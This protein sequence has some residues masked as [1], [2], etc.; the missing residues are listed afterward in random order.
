MNREIA[1]SES[2]PMIL[3]EWLLGFMACVILFGPLVAVSVFYVHP[4]HL[5]LSATVETVGIGVILRAMLRRL[6]RSGARGAMQA[7]MG[8][9]TR[10]SSRTMTRR[11]AR[12]GVKSL[13]SLF[14]RTAS[15]S[16]REAL[17]ES[18]M[19]SPPKSAL[20]AVGLGFVALL[21]SLG[22][23]F[24]VL[25]LEQPLGE[26]PQLAAVLGGMPFALAV[27][28]GAVPILVYAGLL[29]A[30]AP[31]CGVEIKFRT[32]LEALLLQAY[33]TGSGSF[34]PLST[35]SVV[36]GSPAA[37]ARLALVSL[38]GLLAMHLGF[39]SAAYYFNS[40]ALQ[41]QAGM[42]LLYCFVF[43]FPIAPLDGYSLWAYS[44]W[45]WLAVSIPILA[46]FILTMPAS[47]HVIL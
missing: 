17:D 15:D 13:S 19:E 44:R 43:S 25:D 22:G 41:Y 12:V 2:R 45:L 20:A 11:V 26:A 27:F 28:L 4:E 10:A 33:F 7:T 16:T 31:R 29:L 9:V 47:L 46:A 38:G 8:T 37:C 18:D 34:L 23:V 1:P 32:G 40:Y 14:G 39:S 35:D 6:F 5:Q 36:Q 30:A 42:F 24:L 3:F 21:V